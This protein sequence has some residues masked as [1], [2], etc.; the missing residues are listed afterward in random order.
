MLKLYYLNTI[1]HNFDTLRS[2]PS[3]G[4]YWTPITHIYIKIQ[5]NY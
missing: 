4:N 3:S 2:W 1:C 5:L